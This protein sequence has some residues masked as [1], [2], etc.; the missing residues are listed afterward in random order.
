MIKF[1]RLSG[2]ATIPTRATSGSAGFDLYAA[3]FA[4]VPAWGRLLI[5]TDIAVQLPDNVEGHIRPRSG[6]ARHCAV[7]SGAG[8]IDSD[9]RKPLGVLLIN[10]SEIPYNVMIGDRIAQIVFH[11]YLSDAIEVDEID[12]T[13]RGGF[14]STGK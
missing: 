9:Y 8:T 5:N 14:G 12:D 7:D 3:E 4:A 11:E 2:N 13:D 1:K 10:S 6:L